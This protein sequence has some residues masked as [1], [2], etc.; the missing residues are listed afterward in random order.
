MKLDAQ[1]RD[2]DLLKVGAEA[3]RYERMGFD[4]LWTFEAAHDP[5]LPLM[6]AVA[7]TQSIGVGT[8]ITVAFARSPFAVAQT[9]WDLQGASRGR[10]QLGLGTQVRA[11]VERRFAMPF[12]HPARRIADYIR[13]LR[14]IWETFQNDARPDYQGEFYQF[15][16]INPF[17]NPGP[18]EAPEIPIYLAG[19][20]PR[21]CRT[22]GEVADGF[23]VHPMHS[24]SYLRQVIRPEIDKGAKAAGRAPGELALHASVFAV[25]GETAA[26]RVASEQAVREQVAF[27]ASTPNYRAL[28]EHHGFDGLGKEL[29]A[30]MRA[31][32]FEAM[33]RRVPDRL[34][35]E[36][37]L[38]AE[39]GKLGQALRQ[40]HGG[41]L[42]RVSLYFPIP[43]ADEEVLWK[44]F[45]EDFRAAA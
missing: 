24:V 20:N 27:Y 34:L 40:R 29:S 30:L 33:F 42:D 28:L 2:I 44:R 10:F 35:S 17:F 14:A 38:W 1:M 7:S 15:R 23:H 21:M 13:C 9:A 32:D 41:A 45:V 8:N 12:E 11:H 16:L 5:F 43:E 36:V 19:V 3:A 26:E 22:A 39:P 37:A 31:G 25:T 6:Q 4:A 18:I